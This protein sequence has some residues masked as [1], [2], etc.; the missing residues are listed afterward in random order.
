MIE[1]R[2]ALSMTRGV[3]P[4]LIRRLTEEDIELQSLFGGNV[5]SVLERIGARGNALSDIELGEAMAR[6]RR[7]VEFMERHNIEGVFMLDDDYPVRLSELPD[8]PVL[9]YKLGT[10]NLNNSRMVSM[11]GTRMATPRGLSLTRQ[12]VG[13]MAESFPG[14]GIVSGLAHGIDSAAHNA[15]LEAGL[16][17]IGVLAH[18]LQMIYPAINRELAMRILS[19]G[20]ALLSEYPF[21]TKPYR[22]H[23]LERNRIV[24][25]MSDVTIVVE[26]D[27]KGGAMSTARCADEYN[28]Y[29]LAVPGRPSDRE[30]AGCNELIRRHRA[31]IFTDVSELTYVTGWSPDT[32]TPVQSRNLFPE[33]DEDNRKIYEYVYACE[34]PAHFDD[35]LHSVGIPV[36]QLMA[37]LSELE[38]DGLL[39]RHPG[40]RYSVVK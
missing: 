5:R 17:T 38:F 6:A 28:R 31:E 14:V 21:G 34:Q 26:S 27:I 13:D 4:A 39:V 20:G 30:S 29:V 12:Y 24:A 32:L 33:L 37:L 36:S 8:A 19:S 18:G 40:N 11:V 16:P 7:E 25:G 15:A 2:V 23:F 3:T 35:I 22:G 9:L 10:A 1:I